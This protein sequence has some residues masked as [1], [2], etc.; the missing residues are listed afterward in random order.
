M[1]DLETKCDYVY[2]RGNNKDKKKGDKCRRKG[3]KD[4][5][6]VRCGLHRHQYLALWLKKARAT[7][8]HHKFAIT[9]QE[10]ETMA[11][12]IAAFEQKSGISL[13]TYLSSPSPIAI[14]PCK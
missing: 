2:T 6:G 11:K 8:M 9:K 3:F 12:K 10:C 7:T 5:V 13:D 1:A 4:I 14:S